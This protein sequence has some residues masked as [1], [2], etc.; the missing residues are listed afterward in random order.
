MSQELSSIAVV[1]GALRVGYCYA[2]E[3]VISL[4]SAVK[5]NL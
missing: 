3:C 5:N 1:I 2:T 4:R